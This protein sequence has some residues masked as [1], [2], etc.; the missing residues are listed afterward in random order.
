[1]KTIGLIGGMSWESS[2]EYYRIINEKVKE[3]LGGLH[4]AKLILYSVDFE[5]IQL[6]QHKNRWEELTGRMVDIAK[7]V[8]KAGA[9]MIVIC[10]NTMHKMADDVQK[11]IS[12]P[13]IHIADAT[14]EAIR[15]QGLGKVGLLGTRFTMEQD[16]YKK[17]IS[18]KFNIDVIIP[19]EKERELIHKILYS[20]LCIGKIIESSKS[21]F[22][23]VI[24]NLVKKGA[25]GIILGCTEIP[26]IVKQKDVPVPV[27]DT[28]AIH[29]GKAVKEALK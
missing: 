23:E 11:S 28:T 20:E 29:A 27:F 22:L 24:D 26:L 5:E 6:L 18:D 4:S 10:T 25:G 12:V 15:D 14:A 1:M 13:L 2:H 8:E 3:E 19:C 21:E 16:F 9:D 7:T 17:R